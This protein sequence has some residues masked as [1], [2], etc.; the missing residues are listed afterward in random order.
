LRENPLA[1][2]TNERVNGKGVEGQGKKK[3][4]WGKKPI[5]NKN[6]TQRREGRG[7]EG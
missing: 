3:G 6:R 1:T 4:R 7:F 2:G 5:L